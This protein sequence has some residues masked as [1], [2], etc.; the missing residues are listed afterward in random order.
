MPER[1]KKRSMRVVGARQV[2][3]ALKENELEEAF[4]ALAENPAPGKLERVVTEDDRTVGWAF[5]PA[6]GEREIQLHPAFRKM[7]VPTRI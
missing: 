6:G 4:L 5:T 2:L 3:R 1:L 7:N